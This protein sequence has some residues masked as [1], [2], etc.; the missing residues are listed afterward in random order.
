VT[1]DVALLSIRHVVAW[2]VNEHTYIQSTS[3]SIWYGLRCSFLCPIGVT[4]LF[5]YY[6]QRGHLPRWL[7]WPMSHMQC[8]HGTGPQRFIGGAG[9]QLPDLPVD[10][11][12]EFQGRMLWDFSGRQEDSTVLLCNLWPLASIE[13]S[14]A[15]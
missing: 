15:Q 2:C 7:R 13:F 10:F 3:W 4:K 11:A 8:A 9:I 12:F 14:D 5:R 6:P 1:L